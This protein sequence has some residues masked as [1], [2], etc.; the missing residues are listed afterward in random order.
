MPNKEKSLEEESTELIVEIFGPLF[1]QI[2][3]V[4]LGIIFVVI[5]LI[6]L[7]L[8]GMVKIF[9][10]NIFALFVMITVLCF[11]PL[12]KY[13]LLFIIG[14]IGDILIDEKNNKEK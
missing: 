13:I 12:G 3:K 6:A 2:L 5:V 1:S 9:D 14:A 8:Y 4:V 7:F 10:I 11:T